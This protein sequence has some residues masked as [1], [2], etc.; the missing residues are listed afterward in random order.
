[1]KL[2]ILI[3]SLL[4]MSLLESCSTLLVPHTSEQTTHT[5]DDQI[6]STGGLKITWKTDTITTG[7]YRLYTEATFSSLTDTRVSLAQK[8]NIKPVSSGVL[9]FVIDDL[10]PGNLSGVQVTAG[11][12]R[13]YYFANDLT[14]FDSPPGQIN[15]AVA[16]KK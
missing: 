7:S 3:P 16:L 8:G 12:Q 9:E 5:K 10:N 2:K 6:G 14:Y 13:A 11:K 4:F 15:A 1:M